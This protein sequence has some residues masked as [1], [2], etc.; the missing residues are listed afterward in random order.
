M[1]VSKYLMGYIFF[2]VYEQG[3]NDEALHYAMIGGRPKEKQQA[4]P[5]GKRKKSRKR[6]KVKRNLANLKY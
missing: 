5:P 3:L 6:I 4:I 2:C 1:H